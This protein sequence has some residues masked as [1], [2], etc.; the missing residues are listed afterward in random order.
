MESQRDYC[1]I[2][3]IPENVL[4]VLHRTTESSTYAQ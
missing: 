2:M 3:L 1:L 4:R